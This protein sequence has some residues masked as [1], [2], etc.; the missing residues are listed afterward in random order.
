MS[1]YVSFIIASSTTTQPEQAFESLRPYPQA[2]SCYQEQQ[3][4]QEYGWCKQ[5]IKNRPPRVT[6]GPLVYLGFGYSGNSVVDR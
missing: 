1:K 6:R 2:V 5:T 4:A 3:A